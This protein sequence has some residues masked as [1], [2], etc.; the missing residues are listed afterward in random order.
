MDKAAYTLRAKQEKTSG[1]GPMPG[2]MDCTGQ[3]L[4]VSVCVCVCVCVCGVCDVVCVVWCV[5]VRKK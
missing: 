4:S 5:S 1:S 3:L 2:K